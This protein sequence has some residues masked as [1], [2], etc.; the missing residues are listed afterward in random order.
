MHNIIIEQPL[1]EPVSLD[2][3]K[4]YLRVD[5]DQENALLEQLIKSARRMVE[6]FTS[7]A[8]IS[9]VHQVVSGLDESED[10]GIELPFAPFQSLVALPQ[11]SSGKSVE[12][13]RSFQL[14]D[15]RPQARVFINHNYY[16]QAVAR[17]QYR[18]GY[19]DTA[20]SVPETL[21]QAILLLVADLYENRPGE[22]VRKSGV[23]ALPGL[24]RSLLDPYRIMRFV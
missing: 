14:N 24:V 11:V 17:I 6:D 8:L 20:A 13:V 4:L 1:V 7:R 3:V 18:C 16:S 2:E 21:R 19:G 9:Q 23:K 15:T 5:G 22:G 12:A 10:G